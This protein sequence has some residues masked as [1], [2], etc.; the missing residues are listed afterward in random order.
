MMSRYR[1]LCLIAFW[2]FTLQSV[3]NDKFS[4]SSLESKPFLVEIIDQGSIRKVMLEEEDHQ[5]VG[6]ILDKLVS[7]ITEPVK[8]LMSPKDWQ[9]ALEYGR[10]IHVMYA[11]RHELIC[12]DG[13]RRSFSHMYIV[14]DGDLQAQ[15]IGQHVTMFLT[16]E[17]EAPGSPY[18]AADVRP[19]LDTLLD[20]VGFK[21]D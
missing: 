17:P 7:G 21:F 20:L 4:S 11:S 16:D 13:I 12:R 8:L 10:F 5:Q 2:G 1:I 15:P 18:Q 3:C 14:L 19:Q 9:D 6:Q